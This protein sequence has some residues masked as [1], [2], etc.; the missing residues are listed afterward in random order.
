MTF[1]KA[2][3]KG[4]DVSSIRK[5]GSFSGIWTIE[6]FT[7]IHN[8]HYSALIHPLSFYLYTNYFYYVYSNMYI[9]LIFVKA[10]SREVL[11][12]K[13][14]TSLV[15]DDKKQMFCQVV[16]VKVGISSLKRTN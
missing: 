3:K 14:Q 5:L 10:M 8:S 4:S 15:D 12:T 1:F 9:E 2:K 16:T 13:T 11:K 6:R 7:R